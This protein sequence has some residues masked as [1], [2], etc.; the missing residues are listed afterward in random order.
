MQEAEFE[1][2]LRKEFPV[3]ESWND[4]PRKKIQERGVRGESQEGELDKES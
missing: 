1:V 2:N 3:Q 4:N